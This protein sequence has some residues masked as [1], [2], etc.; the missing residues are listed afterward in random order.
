MGAFGAVDLLR[1]CRHREGDQ[2]NNRHCGME[3][4]HQPAWD[5]RQRCFGSANEKFFTDG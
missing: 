5:D 3:F 4:V 1:L 2:H